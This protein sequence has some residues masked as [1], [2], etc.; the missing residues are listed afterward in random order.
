MAASCRRTRSRSTAAGSRSTA[1]SSP[2]AD[3]PPCP[4]YRA[5]P[6]PAILTSETVFSL[7]QLPARLAVVG[8]GPLGCELAQAFAR[9][10]A[11]VTMLVDG[12]APAAARGAGGRRGGR[13]RA[14]RDGVRLVT[15]ARLV[16]VDRGARSKLL[17]FTSGEQEHR[18]PVDEILVAIGRRANV[19]DLGLD[20]AG[21]AW[22]ERRRHG[23][24]PAA[25]LATR[26][27]TPPATSPR[28][29]SSRT[30]PTPW[31]AWSCATRC[32]GAGS[33]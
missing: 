31:R 33:G 23:R 16:A 27:S 14:R 26:R 6:T 8:G 4:T 9:F 22:T 3:A 10:G 18:L 12:D 24:R 32:S 5:S 13:A 21:V 11:Q 20:A 30:P 2:P 1:P 25:H 17:R 19:A 28:S 15:G 29:T 7:Q